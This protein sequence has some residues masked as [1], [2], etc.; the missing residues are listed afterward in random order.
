MNSEGVLVGAGIALI[1]FALLNP[2]KPI[3]ISGVKLPNLNIPWYSRLFMGIFGV[4][5]LVVAG[6]SN[7][8]MKILFHL[9]QPAKTLQRQTAYQINPSISWQDTG[10]ALSAGQ[11]FRIT[12]SGVVIED[13]EKIAPQGSK[14]IESALD[15]P[16]PGAAHL[17]VV[18]KINDTGNIFLIGNEYRG[19]AESAG[20]LF[21]AVNESPSG[22]NNN[23]GSFTVTVEH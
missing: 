19:F 1:L 22:L 10:V 3:E 18:G 13:N 23:G 20:N 11:E 9:P 6:Y 14:T 15:A 7:E 17:V 21:L 4:V 5:C 8:E 2:K 16:R 12:V